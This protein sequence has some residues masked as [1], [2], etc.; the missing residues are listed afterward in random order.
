MQF[1]LP[2]ALPFEG[3]PIR[4]AIAA[5]DP[6]DVAGSSSLIPSGVIAPPPN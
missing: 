2:R 4:L 6:A 3:A 1:W 5:V